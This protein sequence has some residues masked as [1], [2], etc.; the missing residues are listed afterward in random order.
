[1]SNE[2]VLAVDIHNHWSDV[3]SDVS[4]GEPWLADIRVS[5]YSR[6]DDVITW[7]SRAVW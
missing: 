4:S 5:H 6:C 7:D 3:I 2:A 1:M